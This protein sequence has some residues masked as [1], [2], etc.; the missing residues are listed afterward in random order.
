MAMLELRTAAAIRVVMA[1]ATAKLQD[2]RFR[3]CC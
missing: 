1:F 2:F 3:C